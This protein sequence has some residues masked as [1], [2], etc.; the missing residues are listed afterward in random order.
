MLVGIAFKAQFRVGNEPHPV[1]DRLAAGAKQVCGQS[2][3]ARG[4]LFDFTV[5]V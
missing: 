5:S 4:E 2:G 1:P 3:L